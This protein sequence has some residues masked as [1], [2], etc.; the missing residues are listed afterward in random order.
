M[1]D[2]KQYRLFPSIRLLVLILAVCSGAILYLTR[3]NLNL[4][5][6]SMV[7]YHPSSDRELQS[8]F[9]NDGCRNLYANS[10]S[11]NSKNKP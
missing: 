4:A 10:S 8:N 7:R 3:V 6:V 2:S 5:I 1:T 9:T 11:N